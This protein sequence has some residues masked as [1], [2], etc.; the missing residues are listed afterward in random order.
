MIKKIFY[1]FILIILTVIIFCCKD[2]VIN[3][4][5]DPTTDSCGNHI[6]GVVTGWTSGHLFDTSPPAT[7]LIG[8]ERYFSFNTGFDSI[9]TDAVYSIYF[10][11]SAKDI[12]AEPVKF[13]STANWSSSSSASDTGSIDRKSVV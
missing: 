8:N 2:S 5:T 4:F 11:A 12:P 6:D 7:F 13:E 10:T 1:Y 9:C 3:P